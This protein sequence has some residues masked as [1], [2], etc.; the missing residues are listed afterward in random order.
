MK[1]KND[2]KKCADETYPTMWAH[3]IYLDE[4][5]PRWTCWSHPDYSRKW[6]SIINPE[7]VV[8]MKKLMEDQ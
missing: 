2:C 1:A 3:Y 4:K 6:G 8:N 7:W 5:L